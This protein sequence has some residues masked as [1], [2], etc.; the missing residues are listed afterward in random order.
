MPANR[1][2]SYLFRFRGPKPEYWGAIPVRSS[3]PGA[4]ARGDRRAEQAVE[5]IHVA[6]DPPGEGQIAGDVV[7]EV[8]ASEGV[9]GQRD[10][11]CVVGRSDLRLAASHCQA[12]PSRR[13][14]EVVRDIENHRAVAF[15]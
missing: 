12:E 15:V 1:N 11:R 9:H 2:N 8:D 4:E 13:E 6:L 7:T 10:I 3:E 14:A 5:R